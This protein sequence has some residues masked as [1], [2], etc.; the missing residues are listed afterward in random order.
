MSIVLKGTPALANA[1][2]PTSDGPNPAFCVALEAYLPRK[3]EL[4]WRNAA[5][6]SEVQ[7]NVIVITAMNI[8][9]VARYFGSTTPYMYCCPAIQR[10]ITKS[11]RGIG[12]HKKNKK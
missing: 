4:D 8:P 3:V 5:I 7:S 9:L 2:F 6:D 12:Y 10:I 11:H 1:Y